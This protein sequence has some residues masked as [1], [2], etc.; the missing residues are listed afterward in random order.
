MVLPAKLLVQL[1][2]QHV[3]MAIMFKV[4]LVMTEIQ[5]IMMVAIQLVPVKKLVGHVL[6]DL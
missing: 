1:A 3:V 4:K 5:A 6:E 2:S